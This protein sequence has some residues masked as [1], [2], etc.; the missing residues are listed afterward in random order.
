MVRAAA[1]L[2]AFPEPREDV[3]SVLLGNRLPDLRDHHILPVLDVV[4]LYVGMS[5]MKTR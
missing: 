1:L 2:A 5:A 4:R 3:L